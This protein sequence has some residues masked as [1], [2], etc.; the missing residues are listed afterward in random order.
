[1][2]SRGTRDDDLA[3]FTLAGVADTGYNIQPHRGCSEVMKEEAAFLYHNC[4]SGH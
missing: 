4:I 3:V 2:M 1:M